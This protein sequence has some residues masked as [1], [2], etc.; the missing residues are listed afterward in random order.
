M[1]GRGRPRSRGRGR[2]GRSISRVTDGQHFNPETPDEALHRIV[3]SIPVSQEQQDQLDEEEGLM[4][5]EEESEV[6]EEVPAADE[7]PHSQSRP[8]QKSPPGHPIP[9][10]TVHSWK[11]SWRRKFFTDWRFDA[12]QQ[13]VWACCSIEGCEKT[14]RRHYFAGGMTSF[15][16]FTRHLSSAHSDLWKEYTSTNQKTLFEESRQQS[17]QSFLRS[18]V[19][20]P[21][22]QQKELDIDLAYSLAI[23]NI[24]L[25]VLRRQ[26]FR[27]WVNVWLC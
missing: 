26:R 6:V 7:H 14:S 8:L 23:D 25:N 17:I 11:A 16:N 1:V 22:N 4:A 3:Q 15:T 2:G 19:N 10:F 24:P 12:V 21:P 27:K 5:T 9:S 13:R 20:L 18:P